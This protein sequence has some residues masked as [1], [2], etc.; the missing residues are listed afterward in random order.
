MIN[1]SFVIFSTGV[2]PAVISSLPWL[3][4][5]PAISAPFVRTAAYAARRPRTTA[6]SAERVANLGVVF[7][8]M[9]AELPSDPASVDWAMHAVNADA[10]PRFG[11]RRVHQRDELAP[12]LRELVEHPV[13]I[14][15]AIISF[16][17][18]QRIVQRWQFRPVFRDD[19]MHPAEK[20]FFP[21]PLMAEIF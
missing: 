11:R 5:A 18:P 14:L 4:V 16:D 10:V 19:R 8:V 9:L 15:P 3:I 17:L 1:S 13:R 7:L 12:Q 2:S 6:P 21:I 20:H